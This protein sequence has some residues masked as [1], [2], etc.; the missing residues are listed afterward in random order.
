MAGG[1]ADAQSLCVQ[2]VGGCLSGLAAL[3]NG[4]SGLEVC[5]HDHALYKS[6]LVPLILIFVGL[7]MCACD[8]SKPLA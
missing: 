4:E 2:V 8:A 7:G 5:I 3:I 6:T 1:R